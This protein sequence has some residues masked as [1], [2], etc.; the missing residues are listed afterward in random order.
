MSIGQ[1]GGCCASRS[2]HPV[3]QVVVDL[4]LKTLEFIQVW[5]LPAVDDIV[6][7]GPFR[8]R[9]FNDDK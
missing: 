6:D 1:G 4:R 2:I 9:R 8:E 3:L 5:V 7:D